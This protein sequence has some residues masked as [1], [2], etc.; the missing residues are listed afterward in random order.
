LG[1]MTALKYLVVSENGSLG[2][3]L[4]VTI[5]QLQSLA[6]LDIR[7]CSFSGTLPSQLGSLTK[8]T[9]LNLSNNKFY[10]EIPPAL[11]ELQKFHFDTNPGLCTTT[12]SP[13]FRA[14]ADCSLG[15]PYPICTLAEPDL[16]VLRELQAVG[17]IDN[18]TVCGGE[19][20]PK[21]TTEAVGGDDGGSRLIRIRL[22]DLS[23]RGV[24]TSPVAITA[25]DE[26]R[27]QRKPN[28]RRDACRN[29]E[30][31]QPSFSQ[32]EEHEIHGDWTRR[33]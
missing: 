18:S 11:R 13:S 4:P 12:M 3:Q 30:L 27:C 28:E 29:L 20:S 16:S 22:L 8:L 19:A 21:C 2:G 32:Y 17:A 26:S 5:S 23:D 7:K 31:D 1:D 14:L 10:G 33:L 6:V 15:C 9:L 24:S 25:L